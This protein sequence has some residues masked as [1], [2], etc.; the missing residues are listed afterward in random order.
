MFVQVMTLWHS[1]TMSAWKIGDVKTEVAR[2]FREALD[3]RGMTHSELAKEL[4]AHG[5]AVS[6]SS[7]TK[8]LNGDRAISLEMAMRLC[9][10]LGV[11]WEELLITPGGPM[12]QLKRALEAAGRVS[13]IA[14]R[15]AQGSA[16]SAERAQRELLRV[17]SAGG[18][19]VSVSD[20]SDTF[21]TEP[22][23][24]GEK[25]RGSV[26]ITDRDAIAFR[27]A[28]EKLTDAARLASEAEDQLHAARALMESSVLRN[29]TRW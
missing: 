28:M 8:M 4:S 20:P 9:E 18:L 11:P 22:I 12:V 3:A 25:M 27:S 6:Q 1:G 14:A 10:V 29:W 5:R 2:T 16:E 26:E 23:K 19:D 17:M 15:N 7:V 24:D 21:W 13:D